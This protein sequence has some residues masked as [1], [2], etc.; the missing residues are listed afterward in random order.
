MGKIYAS[1]N[2][3]SQNPASKMPSAFLVRP[4]GSGNK[5]LSTLKGEKK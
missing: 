3:N 4:P 5:T 2:Q 1:F